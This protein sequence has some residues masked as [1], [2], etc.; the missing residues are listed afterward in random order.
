VIGASATAKPLLD[1]AGVVADAG[2]L[3]GKKADAFLSTAARGRIY[4]REASVRTI[5]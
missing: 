1:A 4:A 5:Y 3:S 2:V